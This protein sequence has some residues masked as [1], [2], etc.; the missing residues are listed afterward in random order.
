MPVKT[1][2][3]EGAQQ[4]LA[5]QADAVFDV[6]ATYQKISADDEVSIDRDSDAVS[7]GVV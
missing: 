1:P 7:Q 4:P 5:K 3:A 6:Y 2:V